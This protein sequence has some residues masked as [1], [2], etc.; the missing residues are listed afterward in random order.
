MAN[1]DILCWECKRATVVVYSRTTGDTICTE[2][3]LVLEART[4]DNTRKWHTFG[5]PT[6]PILADIGLYIVISKPT[7]MQVESLSFHLNRWQ[8]RSSN[9]NQNILVA[10]IT[11]DAMADRSLPVPA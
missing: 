10:F 4:K 11:I 6:D 7:G 9:S 1:K 5:S 3:S 2:C 8:S